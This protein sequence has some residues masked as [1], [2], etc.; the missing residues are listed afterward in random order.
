MSELGVS[1]ITDVPGEITCDTLIVGGNDI[2][3]LINSKISESSSSFSSN[4]SDV[5]IFVASRETNSGE[6]TASETS[7]LPYNKLNINYGGGF[8]TS[9]YKYT[10]PKSGVYMFTASVVRS[11]NYNY[12]AEMVYNDGSI[13]IVIQKM[14]MFFF[15]R[16]I[17]V[18]YH[19]IMGNTVF[20][21]MSGA[22]RDNKLWLFTTSY[23]TGHLITPT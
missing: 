5:I 12:T 14:D 19:C 16:D 11:G 21:R 17:T 6:I 8:D 10:I 7:I 2:D 22:G 18:I 9:T 4:T 23:F 13:D 3:T 1:T 15:A 20:C